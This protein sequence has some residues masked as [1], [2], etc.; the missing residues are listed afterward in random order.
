M[1]SKLNWR[2]PP[3][4]VVLVFDPPLIC[5][6]SPLSL[7][8]TSHCLGILSKCCFLSWLLFLFS[9]CSF[10][11]L[12]FLYS[13]LFVLMT[14]YSFFVLSGSWIYYLLYTHCVCSVSFIVLHACFFELMCCVMCFMF[15]GKDAALT[16][17]GFT[18]VDKT[19]L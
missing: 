14:L 10:L 18:A 2:L 19:C 1:H 9:L 11:L 5:H 3:H 4:P 17:G 12:A 15:E 16:E 6:R 8:Q 7:F 13:H